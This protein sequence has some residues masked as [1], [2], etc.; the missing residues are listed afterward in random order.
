MWRI[1]ASRGLGWEFPLSSAEKRE[2]VMLSLAGES[3][4]QREQL[5]RQEEIIE[6]LQE[7]SSPLAEEG[8]DA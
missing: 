5:A 8:V 7:D 4:A 3:M 6:M 1:G 2:F